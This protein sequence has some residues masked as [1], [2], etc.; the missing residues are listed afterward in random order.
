MQSFTKTQLDNL[1]KMLTYRKYT[2]NTTLKSTDMLFFNEEDGN[3]VCVKFLDSEKI[4]VDNIRMFISYLNKHGYYHG[5]VIC[6]NEPSIQVMKE[7]SNTRLLGIFFEIFHSHQLNINISEHSLV[8]K[9]TLLT[10]EE[11]L[12][13]CKQYNVTFAKFPKIMYNDAMAR[14]IGAK[15]GDMIKI[16]KNGEYVTYRYVLSN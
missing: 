11:G 7:I 10:K 1:H 9:H 13:L 15:V 8:P 3:I 16:E 4:N 2:E 5:I 12:Q 6:K 14:Y